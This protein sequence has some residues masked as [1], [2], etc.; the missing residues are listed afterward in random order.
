MLREAFENVLPYI[1]NLSRLKSFVEENEGKSI[2][3]IKRIIEE[4]IKRSNET[5]RT[6]FK[7][8][9]N[10]LEKTINKRM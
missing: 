9:L 8:L 1:T 5:L 6:D 7:I 10:E 3:E 2:E 4:E